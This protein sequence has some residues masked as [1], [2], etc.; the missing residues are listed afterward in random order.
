MKKLA[1]YICFL[2]SIFFLIITGCDRDKSGSFGTVTFGEFSCVVEGYVYT[3]S[4]T[5][6]APSLAPSFSSSPSAGLGPVTGESPLS[7]A[8]VS[9]RNTSITT[10]T[11]Q[12]GYFKLDV[13]DKNSIGL[14]TIEFKNSNG[15]T[16]YGRIVLNLKENDE[17]LFR[18]KLVSNKKSEVIEFDSTDRVTVLNRFPIVDAGPDVYTNN[19]G[20]DYI[21]IITE[22]SYDPD[23]PHPIYGSI[24]EVFLDLHN[25]FAFDRREEYKSKYVISNLSDY[26]SVP[27]IYDVNIVMVD[28]MGGTGLGTMRVHVDSK[29]KYTK[30]RPQAFIEESLLTS[31]GI[32]TVAGGTP[33]TITGRAESNNPDRGLGFEYRWVQTGGPTVS[34]SYSEN[35]DSITFTPVTGNSYYFAFY[36]KEDDLESYPANVKVVAG[37]GETGGQDPGGIV[38]VAEGFIYYESE[39]S[40]YRLNSSTGITTKLTGDNYVSTFPAISADFSTVYFSSNKDD[41]NNYDIYSVPVSGGNVSRLLNTESSQTINRDEFMLYAANNSRIYFVYPNSLNSISITGGDFRTE[42]ITE[43]KNIRFPSVDKECEKIV[44]S[45]N[46]DTTSNYEL[47]LADLDLS[48]QVVVG[49]IQKLT[50]GNNDF[51]AKFSPDGE[52]IVFFRENSN[53]YSSIYKLELDTLNLVLLT[54]D[55]YDNTFP[56]YSTDGSKIFYVSSGRVDDIGEVFVMNNDGTNIRRLTDNSIKERFLVF[57]E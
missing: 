55:N 6:N 8:V 57:G 33:L 1:I 14:K 51:G 52:N 16:L 37:T 18:I 10:T 34:M 53:G 5:G 24:K 7:G 26:F 46:R 27:G 28:Y 48:G 54:V 31:E 39:N 25:Q 22:K 21:K 11:D 2:I 40:I 23:A 43:G 32:I 56:C 50:T 17:K 29:Y 41:N 3:I 47:Y 20:N 35:N 15:Q 12:Y 9:L 4:S 44:F 42:Y 38:G 49:S 13:K 45:S 30:F 36:A 19:F